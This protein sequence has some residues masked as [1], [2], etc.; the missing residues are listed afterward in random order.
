MLLIELWPSPPG[1]ALAA[2]GRGV[3]C[4]DVPACVLAA[5]PGLLGCASL[6]P[7]DLVPAP[8]AARVRVPHGVR[9]TRR[10]ARAGL[11]PASPCNARSCTTLFD[12]ELA[13]GVCGWMGCRLFMERSAARWFLKSCIFIPLKSGSRRGQIG[14]QRAGPHPIDV[15]GESRAALCGDFL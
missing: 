12:A 8:A 2:R 5:A 9:T 6:A 10:R 11:S 1:P 15:Y 3:R 14:T 13:K 7:N 4:T